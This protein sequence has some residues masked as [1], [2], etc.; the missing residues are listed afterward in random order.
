M[1]AKHYWSKSQVSAIKY[2]LRQIL[3]DEPNREFK[4]LAQLKKAYRITYLT[5]R[6][7]YNEEVYADIP[8]NFSNVP[9]DNLEA[10]DRV[11]YPS[12]KLTPDQVME[13]RR[14]RFQEKLTTSQIQKE[15]GL[16]HFAKMTI[17]RAAEGRRHADIPN[18]YV[19]EHVEESP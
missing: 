18:P 8:P 2:A 19:N 4:T 1:A 13:I 11:N 7:F 3:L 16:E 10:R 17:W 12:R 14:L 5:L 9:W 15:L 6:R